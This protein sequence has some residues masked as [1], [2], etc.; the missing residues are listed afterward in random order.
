MANSGPGALYTPVTCFVTSTI[1]RCTS[2]RVELVRSRREDPPIEV[3]LALVLLV[4]L[5][6]CHP[7]FGLI[8]LESCCAL[9]PLGWVGE[10]RLA[11]RPTHRAGASPR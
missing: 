9:A 5:R 2:D 10:V 11:V 7:R 4:A 1:I 8:D 6:A 3:G